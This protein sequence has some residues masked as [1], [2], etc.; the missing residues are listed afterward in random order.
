MTRRG[1]ISEARAIRRSCR[2]HEAAGPDHGVDA[3]GAHAGAVIIGATGS[4]GIAGGVHAGVAGAGAA[5]CMGVGAVG[6]HVGAAGM[7][8]A[9]W[10]GVDAG[11]VHAGVAGLGAEAAGAG[12]VA[13]GATGDLELRTA[14]M[15]WLV[16]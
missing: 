14:W 1:L 5:V 7:G 11:A 13:I 16:A 2:F 6:V 10:A 4:A 3:G 15:D 8:A 9:T 12:G